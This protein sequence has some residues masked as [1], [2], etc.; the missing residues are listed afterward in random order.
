ML[1]ELI[2]DNRATL[3]KRWFQLILE[4]FSP[5]AAVFLQQERDPFLNPVGGTI[6]REIEAILDELLRGADADSLSGPLDGIV[7]IQAVQD[8]LPSQ[9]VS[10]VFLLKRAVR[11]AL[12][13]V[14]GSR[15]LYEELLEFES[16]VDAAA[17]LAFDLYSQRREKIHEIRTKEIRERS[18]RFAERINRIYGCQDPDVDGLGCHAERNRSTSAD[19]VKRGSAI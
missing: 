5:D 19:D 8:V 10:F 1:A 15:Q 14:A 17:L 12:K 13:G 16:R 2:Q 11:E 3:L 9:A 7:K 6:S 4:G 18:G